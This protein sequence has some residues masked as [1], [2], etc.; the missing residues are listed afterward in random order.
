MFKLFSRRYQMPLWLYHMMEDGF[1]KV[2]SD[3]ELKSKLQE[4]LK[5]NDPS[6]EFKIVCKQTRQ[7]V[8]VKFNHQNKKWESG[9]KTA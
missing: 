8:E 1:T 9:F 7:I 6:K 5:T 3:E 2:N 4:F